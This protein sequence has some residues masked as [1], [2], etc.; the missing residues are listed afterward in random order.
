MTFLD[1]F[2]LVMCVSAAV[3][4]FRLGFITRALSW[5]G[6]VGGV[7]IALAVLPS[8][9]RNAGD[10]TPMGRLGIVVLIALL[11][12]LLGQMLGLFAGSKLISSLPRGA[13][14]RVDQV[15]G[16]FIGVLGVLAVLWILVP[17]A[18]N[19]PGWTA[20]EAR[21]S[22]LSQKLFASAPRPP[23]ITSTINRLVGSSQ[24]PLVF[25]NLEPAIDTG[26]P[27][28][29]LKMTMATA[30]MVK[31]STVKVEGTACRRTQDGSGFSIGDGYVVTNAHVVAGEKSTTI[32]DGN[33]KPHDATLVAY[34][35]GRDLA[36]LRAP[37]YEAP[38]LELKSA[39]EGDEGAVFGHPGG[40]NDVAISPAAVRREITAVGRDLYDQQT[41]R[42]R[43]LVLAAQLAQGDSGG[44]LV[45][46][47][48]QVIG[49]AFAIAPD[50]PG[51]SYALDVSEVE[52]ILKLPLDRPVSSGACV[53]D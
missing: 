8:I 26:P 14:R 23:N 6:L 7:L 13:L 29:S 4:G 42:R 24:F 41:T 18:A 43:V 35:P 19:V 25:N 49:V 28:A 9:L 21:S 10:M 52:A 46:T 44:P 50:K 15:A 2:A 5:L 39:R 53:A 30:E 36:V 27:P 1:W 22:L 51:T 37:T 3:A 45:N 16:A 17:I 38:A 12:S 48:G 33:Q 40:Q 32:F 11:G 47:N 31:A 34:D 20:H